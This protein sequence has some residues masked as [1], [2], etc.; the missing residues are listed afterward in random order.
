MDEASASCDWP[1]RWQQ[2]A[3]EYNA[4]FESHQ[5][6]MRAH[7]EDQF[8]KIRRDN[9][10]QLSTLR[11]KRDNCAERFCD[12]LDE[13]SELEDRLE[14]LNSVKSELN[15]E[16]SALD[17]QLMESSK[18][19]E[20]LKARLLE[21]ENESRIA[22][23]RHACDLKNLEARKRDL[24]AEIRDLEGFVE[25]NDKLVRA[26]GAGSTILATSRGNSGVRRRH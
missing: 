9:D 8:D 12:L 3:A 25:M 6:R 2:I 11:E 4:S 22:S 19:A 14:D 23:D 5:N 7:F 16:I 26:E 17:C 13:A 15:R 21:E 10:D 20:K 1:R 18:L 24:R